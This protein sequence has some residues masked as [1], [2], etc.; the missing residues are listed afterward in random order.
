M[1]PAIHAAPSQLD[2]RPF[3][4]NRCDRSAPSE[5]QAPA[6]LIAEHADI[7]LVS[8]GGGG[9]RGSDAVGARSRHVLR[10]RRSH[11]AQDASRLPRLPTQGRH[12]I[13]FRSR[14]QPRIII[15]S[16]IHPVNKVLST[17]VRCENGPLILSC[18][19][20]REE[21]RTNRVP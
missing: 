17:C 19:N 8:T 6:G 2:R 10:I 13:V 21:R 14:R 16:D 3:D 15:H 1:Q 18:H 11:R 12:W 20:P 9:V 7:L 5:C 4:A